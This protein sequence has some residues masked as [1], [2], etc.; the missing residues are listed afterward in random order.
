MQWLTYGSLLN[1]AL[2]E[3][4]GLVHVVHGEPQ[5]GTGWIISEVKPT[6]F[7]RALSQLISF[8]FPF[9]DPFDSLFEEDDED[10]DSQRNTGG[11]IV[12]DTYRELLAPYFPEW[13]NSFTLSPDAKYRDGI[14]TF[15]VSL[16]KIWRR[17]AI[18]A[19]LTLLDL[20]D[21]IQHAFRFDNDHL[22]SFIYKDHFGKDVSVNHFL[23]D[24]PPYSN[25]IRIGDTP[26]RPG[27]RMNYIFD[28]GDY[29]EFEILLEAIEPPDPEMKSAKIIESQGKAPRQ[30][31]R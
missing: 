27:Q 21:A 19:G 29:W 17:I 1:I 3:M 11:Q 8:G 31:R 24:E 30:Y 20:N 7:G 25:Q 13:Q 28:Y 9:Q 15:K 6:E 16:G 14:F 4:F 5:Q 23:D 26:I 2:K 22:H 10:D 18:P 12:F